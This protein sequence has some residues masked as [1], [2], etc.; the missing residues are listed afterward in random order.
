VQA[1][2]LKREAADESARE[3]Y[4]REHPEAAELMRRPEADEMAEKIT[5]DNPHIY[6]SRARTAF[7]D[8]LTRKSL[9]AWEAT[10]WL[11]RPNPAIFWTGGD[12]SLSSS[13]GMQAGRSSPMEYSRTRTT[14]PWWRLH[15]TAGCGHWG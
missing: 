11:S 12:A 7:Y 15:C 10:A 3:E 13:S 6:A 14:L 1:T 8:L 9:L 2:R 4:K 5:D